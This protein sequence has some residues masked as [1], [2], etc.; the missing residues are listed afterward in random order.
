MIKMYRNL[1]AEMVRFDINIS[2]LAKKLDVKDDTIRRKIHG[3]ASFT[4][5]EALLIQKS[6]FKNLNVEYLF[7]KS[8]FIERSTA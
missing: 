4:V 3:K 8:E 5:E 2:S 1:K 7:Q 6:F